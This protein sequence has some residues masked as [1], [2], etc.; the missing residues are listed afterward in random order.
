MDIPYIGFIFGYNTTSNV[1][2]EL[3]ILLTVNVLDTKNPQEELIRAT[4]PHSRKLPKAAIPNCFEHNTFFNN[5]KTRKDTKIFYRVVASTDEMAREFVI[6]AIGFSNGSVRAFH[7]LSWIVA[8]TGNEWLIGDVGISPE[9]RDI[10]A[11]GNALGSDTHPSAKPLKGRDIISVHRP[12]SIVHSAVH[13]CP[14]R[15]SCPFLSLSIVHKKS[16][17]KQD[18]G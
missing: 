16:F 8:R 14:F 1:R 13:S 2:T 9:G 15:P 3:L 12:S 10:P 11:Q 4:K 7:S 17:P 5:E 6:C 18:S